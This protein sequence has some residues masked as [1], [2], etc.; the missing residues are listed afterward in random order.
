MWQ[1]TGTLYIH[2][3]ADNHVWGYNSYKDITVN[4]VNPSD[5]LPSCQVS[6]VL[7]VE[8]LERIL[9]SEL[10]LSASGS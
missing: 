5:G 2:Y 4:M 8:L 3:G 10:L 6:S 9:L 7:S 1:S